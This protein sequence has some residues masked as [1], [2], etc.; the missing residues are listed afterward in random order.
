ML[1]N[2][3][4]SLIHKSADSWEKQEYTVVA[5]LAL[6]CLIVVLLIY[7]SDE[8]SLGQSMPACLYDPDND[9]NAKNNDNSSW[10][11]YN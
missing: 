10:N 8:W 3:W 1:E 4:S 6:Y 7:T 2:L 11:Q 9:R 5:P